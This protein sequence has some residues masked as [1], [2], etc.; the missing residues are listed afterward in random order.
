MSF[1]NDL[2]LI[3]IEHVAVKFERKSIGS[4]QTAMCLRIGFCE[5]H[6]VIL[7]ALIVKHTDD[8]QF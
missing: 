5:K 7:L 1:I 8:F 6:V 4:L 2:T 3:S